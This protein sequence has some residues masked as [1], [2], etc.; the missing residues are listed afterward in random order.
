MTNINKTK[1][2]VND[3]FNFDKL[4][5]YLNT[6]N[7]TKTFKY[8]NINIFYYGKSDDNIDLDHI[9]KIL[10]RAY[11][12]TKHI[13]KTFNIHLILSPLKK[14]FDG[15]VLST[16]NCNSGLTYVYSNKDFPIVNIYII[17]NEEFG[18]VIIHEIIHHIT[19][20]HSSFK[21]SNINKLKKHFK[22]SLKANIDPNETIVEFC[23]TIFHL[24]Q[25]SL[26]T[27]TDLYKLF[28]EEL[29][30]SLYKTKQLLNLQK[31]MPNG[32]WYEESHIYCY[33]IFKTIIMYNL[34][35]F[36]KI[37]TYPYNDDIITDFIINHSKFLS[38]LEKNIPITINRPSN[39]LCF[40]V[41]SD[42]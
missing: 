4:S 19:L 3:Y 22:I 35:E 30:Y 13:N 2:I 20:I 40:M 33:I 37:Y 5:E 12:I 32:I 23:A 17:R 27:N 16:K 26:E 28:K 31:K 14:K 41:H 15:L 24:Y 9:K 25:I 21:L 11:I 42:L 39:S 1:Q 8:H 36:L 10:K 29:N 38:S 18:K 34:S 7:T 6:I